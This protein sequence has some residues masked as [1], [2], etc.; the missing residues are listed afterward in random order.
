MQCIEKDRMVTKLPFS[1]NGDIN[2]HGSKRLYTIFAL[3]SV[4]LF[5]AATTQYHY[6]DED[7]KSI[8]AFAYG[9]PPTA[10]P[11]RY[12]AT[13]LSITINNGTQTFN[14]IS[15]TTNSSITF[16]A[17]PG[18]GYNVTFTLH[19]A[20]QSSQN[21]TSPGSTWYRH[22][23]YGFGLGKCT[24]NNLGPNRDI[25]LSVHI[26][27]PG[28]VKENSTQKVEW[29]SWP[30]IVQTVF[31]VHWHTLANATASMTSPASTSPPLTTANGSSNASHLTSSPSSPTCGDTITTS[32]RLSS[33]IICPPG[34]I[35]G[36]RIGSNGTTLDLNGHRITG[37]S[38]TNHRMSIGIKVS[39]NVGNVTLQGPGMIKG[40]D[41]GIELATSTTT[42]PNKTTPSSSLSSSHADTVKHIVLIGNTSSISRASNAAGIRVAASSNNHITDNIITGYR[43]FGIRIFEQANYNNVTNNN[44]V[45]NRQGG[46]WV[47]DSQ[48]NH[49]DHN[50]I[51]GNG[52][53]GILVAGNSHNNTIDGNMLIDNNPRNNVN[54]IHNG[55]EGIVLRTS[56]SG[57]AINRN[58]AV[59]NNYADAEDS[60][61]KVDCWKSNNIFGITRP[62]PLPSNC[63]Q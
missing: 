21:N 43:Q 11:N 5:S 47:R 58:I 18:A 45:Y 40:F 27:P 19:T 32:T 56:S 3:A 41:T 50:I 15:T 7:G 46:I 25:T 13:L 9:D 31:R 33:D 53:F 10:C 12:D 36:L 37:H 61:R 20:D 38:T 6:I 34:M 51:S 30:G 1:A 14:P 57:T 8:Q 17:Q 52:L 2:N 16:D 39:S 22:T 49:L 35:V 54:S 29:G 24:D 23:A 28:T 48:S 26:E 44:L 55:G 59:G 63:Q 60:N 62:S 4:I 42:N